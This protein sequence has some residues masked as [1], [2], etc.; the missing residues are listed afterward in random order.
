MRKHWKSEAGFTLVELLVAMSVLLIGIVAT[1]GVFASSKNANL[2][3]QRHEVA[4]HQAQREMERLRALKYTELGLMTPLP[5]HSNDP[6]DPNYRIQANGNFLVKTSDCG[7]SNQPPCEEPLVSGD[8]S[9]V[10]PGPTPFYVGETGAAVSGKV[11]RY[12]TWR[13][14]NCTTCTG[15][16]NTKRLYVAVTIDPVPGRPNIGPKKPVWLSSIAIDPNDGPPGGGGGTPAPPSTAA[17]SFYLYDKTCSDNDANNGYT[18][19]PNPGHSPTNDTA[20]PGTSCENVVGSKRPDLMG[21]TAPTYS[22]PPE[23]AWTFSS[24][25]PNNPPPPNEAATYPAG[26]ALARA[27][28]PTSCPVG[29]YTLDTANNDGDGDTSTPGKWQV[30]AWSTRTFS[31]DFT[32]SGSAFISLW[33]TS[34]GGNAAPGRF[35]A[36]LLDRQVVGGVPNDVVVGSMSRTRT[37]WPTTKVE[38]GR[39][40]GAAD[41]PCGRQLTFQFTLSG[42]RVAAGD[43][44][45]LVISILGTSEKDIVLLY[46]DPRYRSL[47]QL[48]TS[49]PCNADGNPC[50]ST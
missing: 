2:V 30:H 35:C 47:L 15:T 48:E 11:Y 19:P 14:E 25:I 7:G 8:D 33:T 16:Q 45:V 23:P 49:T 42:S 6:N 10:E 17:Q 34:V 22:N 50:Y 12:V 5:T 29:S 40:C 41:F 3:S 4:V 24:D 38:P 27:G 43:R 18:T 36:T 31:Q 13:D 46:D 9:R 21:P 1:F 20:A 37:P 39:N 26:L 28:A 44:L 32:L